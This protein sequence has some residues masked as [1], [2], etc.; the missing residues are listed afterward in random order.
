[1]YDVIPSIPLKLFVPISI[2]NIGQT[3]LKITFTAKDEP[4]GA[5]EWSGR[6]ALATATPCHFIK[7]VLCVGG[8]G[9]RAETETHRPGA[10]PLFLLHRWNL[11]RDGHRGIGLELGD[12]SHGLRHR[13]G[14]AVELHS[15]HRVIPYPTRRP[16]SSERHRRSL[17]LRHVRRRRHRSI[18]F[19]PFGSIDGRSR[20]M[21]AQSL[22]STRWGLLLESY[23]LKCCHVL[24]VEE[25]RRWLLWI[26]GDGVELWIL[27]AATY[28]VCTSM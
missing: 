15:T 22:G 20:E 11:R 21:F 8:S 2:Y 4:N 16:L 3:K 10:P 7:H 28:T 19:L 13:H 23:P 12:R 27:L 5:Q 6:R 14:R 17:E 18:L 24:I 25:G 1:M 26:C 9:S